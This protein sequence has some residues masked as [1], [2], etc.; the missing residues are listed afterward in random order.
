MIKTGS[1]G[2]K[3]VKK[4]TR[5]KND[6]REVAKNNNKNRK[7]GIKE[8]NKAPKEE[9]RV[10]ER[11]RRTKESARACGTLKQDPVMDLEDRDHKNDDSET[12]R[13]ILFGG[14]KRRA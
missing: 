9:K 7:N 11:K 2:L 14:T 13:R 5:M 6:G 3:N 12:V 4:K 10:W 8:R 1:G